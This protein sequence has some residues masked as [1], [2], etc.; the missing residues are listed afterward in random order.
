MAGSLRTPAPG[1]RDSRGAAA[2]ERLSRRLGLASPVNIYNEAAGLLLDPA[3][4]TADQGRQ[5]RDKALSDRY[6]GRFGGPVDFSQALIL[7][8]PHLSVLIVLMAGSF[9]LGCLAFRR[10]EICSGG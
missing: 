4:R 3:R 2:D 6:T 1:R 10:Q 9:S 8:A 7:A 5:L